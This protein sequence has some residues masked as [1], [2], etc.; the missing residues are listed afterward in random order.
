MEELIQWI[1]EG[2]AWIQYRCLKDLLDR[3]END[4]GVKSAREKMWRDRKIMQLISECGKWETSL[5]KRHNDASHPI[6]KLVFLADL[7]FSI[8]DPEIK[9]VIEIILRHK[10]NEGPFQV[11]SNYPTNFGGSGKDEWLWCLCDAPLLLYAL[12]K[13]GLSDHPEVNKGLDY[14]ASL[15]RENGWPC[16]ASAQLGTFKGPGKKSDACPYANLIML[17][18]LA[19]RSSEQ[20][21]ANC[22]V[23]A[24]AALNLWENS[25]EMHPFLFRMGNDFRKLKVPFVWY[26]ILH[27]ADVISQIPEFH[28]DSRFQEIL[29]IIQNKKSDSNRFTSESIWTKWAEWEFCQKKEPSRWITLCVLRL[30]KRTG[31]WAAN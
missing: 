20:D 2:P 8:N 31:K 14:L 19:A 6:H 24:E 22:R 21:L 29:S 10:S 9:E 5:M 11:L 25:R 7:G 17:K 15:L 4:A 30:L 1:M 16:A 12:F 26:D 3:D 28:K 13:F 23:G 27:L 18:A